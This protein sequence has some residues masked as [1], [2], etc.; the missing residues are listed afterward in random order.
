M[1]AGLLLIVKW[2]VPI[3][4]EDGMDDTIDHTPPTKRLIPC[5]R[6]SDQLT[7]L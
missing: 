1:S 7:L 3:I 2:V 6:S 4:T 5:S